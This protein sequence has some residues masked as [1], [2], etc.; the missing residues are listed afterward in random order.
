MASYT[1]TLSFGKARWIER[2][3][4]RGLVKELLDKALKNEENRH[5]FI[6]KRTEV[7]NGQLRITLKEG[8][9]YKI[10]SNQEVLTIKQA[11]ENFGSLQKEPR[12]FK[13]LDV[14][15][16]IAGTGSLGIPRYAVLVEGEG[17]D[18]NY[19]L[20]VKQSRF[21]TLENSL[22]NFNIPQPNWDN[23]AERIVC[24]QQRLQAISPA[25]LNTLKVDSN[26][27]VLKELQPSEDKINLS[28]AIHSSNWDSLNHLMK[29]LGKIIAWAHLRSSGRQGSA[30]ADDFIAFSQTLDWQSAVLKYAQ[31]YSEI[32]VKNFTDFRIKM[33][34]RKK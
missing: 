27:Y 10:E 16:R 3:L 11:I 34:Q 18:R 26:F 1:K 25:L 13:V 21:S 8:K 33:D 17:L 23:P 22:A 7:Q 12:F 20:D 29:S 5:E 14:V 15:G 31:H 6:N 32:V 9:Y 28:E 4:A 2:D 19:F 30:I 24:I